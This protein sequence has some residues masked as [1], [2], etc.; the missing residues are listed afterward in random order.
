MTRLRPGPACTTAVCRNGEA[1][2]AASSD[3]VLTAPGGNAWLARGLARTAA[4]R[5]LTDALAWRIEDGKSSVA[6]DVLHGAKPSA[7]K[8]GK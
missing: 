2:N 4:G 1:A 5:I 6:V 7:S 3:A 8:R